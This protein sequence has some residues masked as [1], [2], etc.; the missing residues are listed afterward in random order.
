MFVILLIGLYTGRVILNALGVEDYGTYNVVGGVVA[1]F[2]ILSS[3]LSSSIS[4]FITY[5]LGQGDIQRLRQIFSTS[6][7]VQL[8]IAGLIVI[9]IEIFGTWFLN[10]YMQIP[11]GRMGAAHFV[12]QCSVFTFALNL[13][14]SPYNAAI[15]AHERM[16]VFAY[17]TILDAVLK[18]AVAFAITVSPYDKLKTYALLL[19][20][21]G[22]LDQLIY[23]I[24][25]RR[26]FEECRFS[27]KFYPD[28]LKQIGS[29]SG[30]NFFGN[31]SWMFNTQGIDILINLFFGVT[32]NAARGIANQ[33][34]NIVQGFVQNFTT[35]LNPQITKSY[36]MGDLAYM[37]KLVF[38]GARYAYYL[39][40]FFAIPICLETKIILQLWL[41][42]VPDY[43]VPF[44]RLTL[45]SAMIPVI[46]QT[47]TVAQNATGRIRKYA[48]V[49]SLVTFLDFPLTYIAFKMGYSPNSTYIIYISIYFV[50]IFVKIRLVKD[51]ISFPVKAFFREVLLKISYVTIIAL[52]PPLL[53]LLLME[54][55]FIRFM[56]VSTISILSTAVVVLYLGMF[57]NERELVLQTISKKIEEIRKR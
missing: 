18:L 24:Y 44:I 54:P 8:F 13:L 39:M 49:T 33:V 56:V 15:I 36:A 25:C 45:I 55:S 41:K 35:A 12:L 32:L 30:W 14:S 17:I 37:N 5:A 42:Q 9:L 7:I 22:A 43:A 28:L 16:G 40:L 2:S 11:E 10:E 1:M 4:R 6:L 23:Y 19:L 26:N 29:F 34:T 20:S 48:I 47:L 38:M 46:T 50:L 31:A 51:Y 57:S 53:M 21:V 27:L 52:I 3:S